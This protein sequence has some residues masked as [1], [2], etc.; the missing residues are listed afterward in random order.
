MHHRI[1]AA[2][3]ISTNSTTT[4]TTTTT[5]FQEEEEASRR[6]LRIINN[7]KGI[8]SSITNNNSNNNDNQVLLF[9][10]WVII[11]L[12]LSF[13][14]FNI[15]LPVGMEI[16]MNNNTTTG[17]NNSTTNKK[18]MVTPLPYNPHYTIPGSHPKVGDRSD[19]Y[20]LFRKEYDEKH[21]KDDYRSLQVTNNLHKHQYD[22]YP[23]PQPSSQSQSRSQ[24]KDE[25]DEDYYY[26]Y[27]DI[28]NCPFNPP[29]GYPYQWNIMNVLNN[30]PTNDIDINT[31]NNNNNNR[32]IY[33][34]LCIFDYNKD[35]D[36]ALIYRN[37][38]LPFVI[39]ND[40]NV[41]QTVE[42]WN[43]PNYIEQMLGRG[44][45][46][47]T[48]Y[49]N[50]N[51]FMYSANVPQQ[52]HKNKRNHNHNHK[53]KPTTTADNIKEE[54]HTN[55]NNNNLTPNSSSSDNNI[56]NN[57]NQKSNSNTRGGAIQQ[58]RR[59]KQQQNKEDKKVYQNKIIIPENWEPPTKLISM[60]Y[61]EW[62]THANRTTTTTTAKTTDTEKEEEEEDSDS[63]LSIDNNNYHHEIVQP[64]EPHWYF[65]LVGCGLMGNH[66]ECDKGSSEYLFDELPYFQPAINDDNDD[67]H[68]LY[69]KDSKE[70][71]GIHCRFGMD[72]VIA[73]NHFDIGRNFIILFKGSRRYILGHPNQ[74]PNF[75]L[76]PKGHP[77]A[78]HSKVDW[79]NPD[80]HL[81]PEFQNAKVNEI[82]LQAGDGLYLPTHWFHYIISL[83]LNY[84]CN[85]RS[86]IGYDYADIIQQCG[87]TT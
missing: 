4:T 43:T 42:R 10:Y 54:E 6:R 26:E 31:N 56:N 66:G 78:R 35:Y 50:N 86:G 47:R 15:I 69:M 20:I 87:F 23:I 45:K 5:T 58:Q 48:E 38:E 77:S 37:M 1:H 53:K 30:W 12:L 49:S 11:I 8:G 25:Q 70:Q 81:Y 68:R 44:I 36:K 32:M 83:E 19:R 14:L 33:Q 65:R 75:V 39:R 59:Q 46:H 21:P 18:K 72:G 67:N 13:L 7:R 55:N 76:Y 64:N 24:N 63:L 2:T 34:G 74:C 57:N 62:L 27:Y 22:T 28:Y 9:R 51:H 79:S 85:T 52:K 60:T 71:S 3:I 84:Q 41:A 17:N 73:E 61:E 16:I 82:I 40:P 80:L 29:K